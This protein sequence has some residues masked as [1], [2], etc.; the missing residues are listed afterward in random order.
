MRIPSLPQPFL[1]GALYSH[2]FAA[3]SLAYSA[4]KVG[5]GVLSA[6]CRT[7]IIY[8]IGSIY[9]I[10]SIFLQIFTHLAR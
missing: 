6:C 9:I 3:T 7:E 2:K 5:Q 4:V 10:Y 8:D 1:G